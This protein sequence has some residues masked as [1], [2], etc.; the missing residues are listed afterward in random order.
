MVISNPLHFSA[1]TNSNLPAFLKS[2]LLPSNISNRGDMVISNLL[3]LCSAV[4]DSILPAFIVN[5][6]VFKSALLPT[7][8]FVTGVIW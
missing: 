6:S 4:T 5:L 1:V 3:Q 8:I 2:A 7:N